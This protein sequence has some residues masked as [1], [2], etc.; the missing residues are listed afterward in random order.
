MPILNF[1]KEWGDAVPFE[2]VEEFETAL[3]EHGIPLPEDGL[4]ENRDYIDVSAAAKTLG[5]KGGEAKTPE[6]A[7]A[8]KSNKLKA[9]ARGKDPGGR[10]PSDPNA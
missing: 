6:K 1:R 3:K 2:N 7:K 10:P 4:L 5:K 9:L 8:A